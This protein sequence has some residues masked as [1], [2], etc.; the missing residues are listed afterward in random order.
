M[1]SKALAVLIGAVKHRA[2]CGFVTHRAKIAPGG[3]QGD[4]CLVFFRRGLVA[5]LTTHPHCGVDELPLLL[6][7]MAGQTR[8]RLDVLLFDERMRDGFFGRNLT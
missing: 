5:V 8:F 6:L 2:L 4:G 1:A 3:D 7:G